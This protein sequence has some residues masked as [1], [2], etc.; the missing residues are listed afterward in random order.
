MN[1]HGSCPNDEK[2]PFRE[3]VN[4]YLCEGDVFTH[5]DR[6]LAL[7][8]AIRRLPEPDKN[9]LILYAEEGSFRRIAK[10]FG[11]THPTISKQIRRIQATVREEVAAAIRRT[12]R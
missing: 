2:R 10:T 3:I 4:D 1:T 12:R 9:L 8:S 11:V 5:D 6:D 7:R